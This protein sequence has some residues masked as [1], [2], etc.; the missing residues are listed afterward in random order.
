[1]KIVLLIVIVVGLLVPPGY[2]Q[3]TQQVI[4]EFTKIYTGSKASVNN[5]IGGFSL[6][7]LIGAVLF[8][9]IG[10]V[11]FMYGKKNTEVRPMII[12]FLLMGYPYLV[13]NTLVLYLVGVVLTVALFVLRE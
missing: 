9:S 4:G 11:A 3:D 5:L 10:F 12:G 13:R 2:C 7:G 1:M 6:G 8:G